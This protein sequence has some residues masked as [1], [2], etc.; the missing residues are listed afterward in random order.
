MSLSPKS[1]GRARLI[2]AAALV[3]VSLFFVLLTALLFHGRN[4]ALTCLVLVVLAMLPFFIR[5][6]KSRPQAR[7]L[8]IIA[9]MSALAVA[10]RAAFFAV[11]Q[12]KPILA[13]VILT[14][15]A[16]GPQAGFLTGA[17]SMLVSNFLFMQSIETPLQ[18]FACG[19]GGFLAGLLYRGGLLRHTWSVCAYGFAAGFLYGVLLDL[20]DTAIFMPVFTIPAALVRVSAGLWFDLVFAAATAF[21]LL[22]QKPVSAALERVKRKFGLMQDI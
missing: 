18:M 4:L 10:G 6:E 3:A 19:L 9:V 5:F 22:P 21:F 16:F 7:E 20:Q 2:F 11:P 17:V 12:F 8:V 14:A 1:A 13:I 15:L